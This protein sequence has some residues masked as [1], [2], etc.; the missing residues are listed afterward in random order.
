MFLMLI[1]YSYYFGNSIFFRKKNNFWVVQHCSCMNSAAIF[2]ITFA[3]S[4][5][6]LH[7]IFHLENSVQDIIN[8]P[9]WSHLLISSPTPRLERKKWEKLPLIF[10]KKIQQTALFEPFFEV[11]P[12]RISIRFLLVSC[13]PYFLVY[14][15]VFACLIWLHSDWVIV[16]QKQLKVCF[17]KSSSS[18][19]PHSLE[20]DVV[21]THATLF[22]NPLVDS[23]LIYCVYLY[24]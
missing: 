5:R 24:F 16:C 13:F 22:F 21:L 4:T 8:T 9:P 3:S 10:C 2:H 18:L 23:M 14:P 1:Y 19:F 12:L 6:Y 7:Y 11:L 20:V 15:S 17:E